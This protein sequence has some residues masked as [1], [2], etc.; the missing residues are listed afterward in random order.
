MKLVAG[1][2]HRSTVHP[3]GGSIATA[4]ERFVRESEGDASCIQATA[5]FDF[6]FFCFAC[7]PMGLPDEPELIRLEDGSLFLKLGVV[8]NGLTDRKLLE[9]VLRRLRTDDFACIGELEGEYLGLLCDPKH[10]AVYLLTDRFGSRPLFY[11][12]TDQSLLFSSDL[13][14]LRKFLYRD[15]T[16]DW[17]G[18]FQLFLYGHTFGQRTT[19]NEIKRMDPATALMIKDGAVR[20][21]TY[22]RLVHRVEHD[23]DIQATARQVFD[24]FQQGVE[25][26]TNAASTGVFALSGGLDSRLVV[27]AASCQ[28]R[29]S[30]FTIGA[31]ESTEVQVARSVAA[32]LGYRHESFALDLYP[33]SEVAGKVVQLTGGLIPVHHPITTYASFAIVKKYGG[34]LL[35]GGPGDVLAG[36]YIPDPTYAEPGHDDL[37]EHYCRDK[38]AL[39][40]AHVRGIFN[41]DAA[42]SLIDDARKSLRSSFDS[43]GG[44]T[45]AHR[46]TAWA[47]QVRQPAFTFNS[48]AHTLPGVAVLQPHLG[49]GYADWMLKLPA[50]WLLNKNFYKYML[51]SCLPNLQHIVYANTGQVLDPT[52]PF[53][54][55]KQWPHILKRYLPLRVKKGIKRM[56]THRRRKNNA[57]GGFFAY[58]S[59]DAD[60]IEQIRDIAHSNKQMREY[61]D[62][63]RLDRHLEQMRSGITSNAASDAEMLGSLVSFCFAL[64]AYHQ[65]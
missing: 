4:F 16:V 59:S 53:P 65:H 22:W 51:Y 37:I 19:V 2:V 63:K 32:A 12:I 21:H 3:D 40:E 58:L 13:H 61:F 33:P 25:W 11:V 42:A 31:P 26:R 14:F 64:K 28:D 52:F 50:R 43:I 20:P 34:L 9:G 49:Y 39:H 46:V 7:V 1:C 45:P 47:M 6:G 41:R 62:L 17:G 23:L 56:M 8:K 10:R 48:P 27:G 55:T 24:V 60:L 18:V 57:A 38:G 30:T 54:P 44:E 15:G 35:G 5:T 36:S 29:F